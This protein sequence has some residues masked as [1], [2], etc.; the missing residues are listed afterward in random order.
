MITPLWNK[1]SLRAGE[2][3]PMEGVYQLRSRTRVQLEISRLTSSDFFP[4]FVVAD[5][6]EQLE[7]LLVCI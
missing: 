4:Q 3:Y 2:K 1:N 5:E 6:T 7:G